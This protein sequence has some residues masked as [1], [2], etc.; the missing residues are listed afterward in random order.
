M[1][2]EDITPFNEGIRLAEDGDWDI[3]LKHLD[4][5]VSIATDK[6]NYGMLPLHWAC[7]EDN[8]PTNV[9]VQL[10][11]A[12]PEG[13]LTKNNAQMLPL[14]IAVRSKAPSASLHVLCQAY[15]GSI[16]IKTRS[17]QKTALEIG[18]KCGLSASGLHVLEKAAKAY[19][20]G[21]DGL[22]TEDDMKGTLLEI[23]R[24]SADMRATISMRKSIV[25]RDSSTR[26]TE[27]SRAS[28]LYES[29]EACGMCNVVFGSTQSKHYCHSCGLSLCKEHLAGEIKLPQFFDKKTVCTKCK[30]T[31]KKKKQ[32]HK[33]H[34]HEDDVVGDLKKRIARLEEENNTMKMKMKEQEILQ[35]ETML[36]LTET[37]SRVASLTTHV[38]MGHPPVEEHDDDDDIPDIQSPFNDSFLEVKE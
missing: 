19:N 17:E 21:D 24:Q 6:D 16:V 35:Q 20:S 8:V 5:D 9:L 28:S 4:I 30:D 37:M 36:L 27:S 33:K 10:I 13:A 14:H 1:S 18:K 22:E 26:S 31:Y 32:S 7:T 29:A 23:E 12:F 2:K 11:K 34:A 3:L 15:P 38:E 25:A